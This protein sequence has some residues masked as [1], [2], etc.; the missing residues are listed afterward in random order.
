M[1]GGVLEITGGLREIALLCDTHLLSRPVSVIISADM[2]GFGGLCV[3]MQ[4]AA[5]AKE[6]DIPMGPYFRAKLLSGLFCALAA[7]VCMLFGAI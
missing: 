5:V 6:N 3:A 7:A 1:L 2:V 4:T